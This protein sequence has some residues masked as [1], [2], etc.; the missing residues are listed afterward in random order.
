ME[1]L[2]FMLEAMGLRTGIDLDALVAIRDLLE[3]NLPD[4]PLHGMIARA[5]VPKGFVPAS[6]VLAAE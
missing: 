3:T 2:V 4:E 5:S 1:D 6:A